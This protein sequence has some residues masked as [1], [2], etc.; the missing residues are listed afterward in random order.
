MIEKALNLILRL[1]ALG[2]RFVFIF[3][4][5]KYAGAEFLG[6][7]SLFVTSITLAVIILGFDLY[8]HATRE[9]I[10]ASDELKSKIILHQFVAY[11]PLYL[12]ILPLL[13]VV[14]LRDYVA[15]EYA[16]LFYLV[17]VFEHIGSEFYRILI[18]LKK[19]VFANILF[20]IR[21]GLWAIFLSLYLFFF[22]GMNDLQFEDIYYVWIICTGIAFVLGATFF[23]SRFN[24]KQVSLDKSFF[25][26]YYK[27]AWRFFIAT[28]A[29]KVIEFSDRYFI[30]EFSTKKMLGVYSMYS[31]TSNVLNIFIY[32]LVIT[33]LYPDLL[34]SIYD[35]DAKSF[36]AIKRKMFIEVLAWSLLAIVAGFLILP[37][38]LKLLGGE[39]Q[40]YSSIYFIL[41]IANV[42]FNLSYIY[43][44]I[45]TGHKRDRDLMNISLFTAGVIL[46][47]NF[48]G[49]QLYGVYGIALSKFVGFFVLLLL[50]RNLVLRRRLALT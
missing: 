28:V 7:Y 6:E 26:S 45:I 36:S 49:I 12:V 38:I 44:F 20:F 37:Y 39:Y 15:W 23:I 32:T 2:S 48:V 4:I 25:F 10:A 13:I 22:G 21:N 50:K 18:P 33:M 35:K 43:H 29:Y 1:L 46:C 3:L 34:K 47:F 31:Q 9:I 5:G 8:V 27:V 42:F 41:I 11:L 14:F 19:V 30:Q 40:L 24:F 17:L 16:H